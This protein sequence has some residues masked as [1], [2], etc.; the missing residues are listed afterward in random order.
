MK[1]MISNVDHGDRVT[2][3]MTKV[4]LLEKEEAQLKANVSDLLSKYD[5][6][7]FMV[8]LMFYVIYSFHQMI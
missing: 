8:S 6:L 4:A 7:K 1:T 2:S 5:E 3:L